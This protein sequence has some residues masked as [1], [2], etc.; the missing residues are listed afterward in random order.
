MSLI[1]P[2][3]TVMPNRLTNHSTNYGNVVKFRAACP[4]GAGDSWWVSTR[5]ES[6]RSEPQYDIR[7]R[8][9]EKQA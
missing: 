5:A 9:K 2:L 6:A 8:H 3:P 1:P 7:C 4:C